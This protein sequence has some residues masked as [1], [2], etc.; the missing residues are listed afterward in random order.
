MDGKKTDF[1]I[2]P[3]FCGLVF[4]TLMVLGSFSTIGGYKEPELVESRPLYA[5]KFAS[6]EKG[7]EYLHIDVQGGKR[8]YTYSVEKDG[9]IVT[10][11]ETQSIKVSIEDIEEPV[12]E[13]YVENLK[14]K[15]WLTLGIGRRKEY[16]IIR[17]SEDKRGITL[18]D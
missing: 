6:S 11:R 12:I 13:T 1:L 8:T 5:L 18:Y 10:E 17:V 9:Y 2:G 14:L 3:I 15:P 16:L 7:E 4:I